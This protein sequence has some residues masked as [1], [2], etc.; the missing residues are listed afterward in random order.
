VVCTHLHKVTRAAEECAMLL[1]RFI[2]PD[3]TT[4]VLLP[5]IASDDKYPLNLAAI[6]MMTQLT[7]NSSNEAI[8]DFLP[9]MIP[10][11]LKVFLLLLFIYLFLL[12][13]FK[14]MPVLLNV[15]LGGIA[16]PAQVISPIPTRFSL[17]WSVCLSLCLSHS[18]I[19]L[20]PFECICGWGSVP[21][22]TGGAYT[23]SPDSLLVG[24]GSLHFLKKP[25][26]TLGFRCR[27]LAL[28]VSGTYV[29]ECNQPPKSTQPG[30]PSVHRHNEYRQKLGAWDVDRHT[31]R[32]TCTISV[33]SQC[34]L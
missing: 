3:R 34:K 23:A 6:K 16:F 10:I 28:Q 24:G 11:L 18:C 1:A 12:V 25:T 8:V 17:A 7:E 2:A 26:P 19:L 31:A 15:S 4:L 30:H 32:Y 29:S 22:P 14:I 5:M 21:V 20:K 13:L 9:E 33:V 27:F